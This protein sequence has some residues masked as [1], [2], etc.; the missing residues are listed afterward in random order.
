MTPC[1][2]FQGN[3]LQGTLP[4]SWGTGP[5][6]Q[7]LVKLDMSSNRLQG[8]LSSQWAR[9][10]ELRRLRLGDNQLKVPRLDSVLEAGHLPLI[11]QGSRKRS[12]ELF[13]GP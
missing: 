13:N 9:M 5:M 8:T 2:A 3:R 6:G 4:F 7:S 11:A 10:S 12:I 1:L